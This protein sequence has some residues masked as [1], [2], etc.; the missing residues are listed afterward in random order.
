MTDDADPGV[1]SV[2]LI[3]GISLTIRQSSQTTITISSTKMIGIQN[4]TRSD[5]KL[6]STGSAIGMHQRSV[7]RF[8]GLV[9][10]REAHAGVAPGPGAG[11]GARLVEPA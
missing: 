9:N 1:I 4:S 5:M 11:G 6:A 8:D 2:G 10:R 3:F 7:E